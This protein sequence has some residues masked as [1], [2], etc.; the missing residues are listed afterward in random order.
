MLRDTTRDGS[1]VSAGADGKCLTHIKPRDL[2]TQQ[3]HYKQGGSRDFFSVFSLLL[4][5]V[6]FKSAV[7][8]ELPFKASA[9]V[10]RLMSEVLPSLQLRVPLRAL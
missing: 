7:F 8:G 9:D 3:Q 6:S 10:K 5:K 4:V 1:H 2:R